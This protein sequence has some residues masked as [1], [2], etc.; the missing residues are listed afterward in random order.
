MLFSD[1]VELNFGILQMYGAAVSHFVAIQ[2]AIRSRKHRN[3]VNNMPAYRSAYQINLIILVQVNP[4]PKIKKK[5]K[6][7][8]KWNM[9]AI[10]CSVL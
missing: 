2:P 6:N 9:I 5:L 3:F 7:K 1:D 8:L 4:K 10:K